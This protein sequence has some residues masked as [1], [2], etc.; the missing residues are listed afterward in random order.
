M[1][2]Q[3]RVASGFS[4]GAT[5]SLEH[6]RNAVQHALNKMPACTVGSVLLFLTNGYAYEPQQAIREAAKTAGTPQVFGCC[7]KGLLTEDEWILDV[8][9]AVA[10]VFPS[11]LGPQPLSI[12]QQQ[13]VTP[14][15]LLTIATP[16]AAIIAV[17]SAE[18]NQ[19]GA[20][21]TD[22]YGDGPYSVWTSGRIV[23]REY[24]HAGFPN[25]LRKEVLVCEG[26]KPLSPA[27]QINRA[28]NHSLYEIDLQD[29]SDN[30]LSYVNNAE[31][32]EFFGLLCAVSETPDPVSLERGFYRLHH[33][34]SVDRNKQLVRISGSVKAG[35]W[36][37]W[38]TRDADTAK[39]HTQQKFD[40]ASSPPS[41]EF[42]LMFPN[43]SR[44][45][46][47]FS[48]V[49]ED[50]RAF[51]SAFPSTPMIGFYGNAEIAPG[52]QLSGLIRHHSCVLN[53][54]W[55]Q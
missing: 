19:F 18:E 10:M 13:G 20:I 28:Q 52:A 4:Y 2:D 31:P 1:T 30:L 9:G 15:L 8:E 25:R 49:D 51:Q 23:E 35:H 12:L 37:R 41:P 16:N 45:A 36:L 21:T 40:A 43:I 44:G 14:D 26:I 33:V 6:A 29:A 34:I 48:G 53:L 39:A 17:N 38:V 11:E 22:E 32:N 7:A 42:A 3:T 47:F 50:L 27:L 46:E 55:E 54:F 24:M 5:A